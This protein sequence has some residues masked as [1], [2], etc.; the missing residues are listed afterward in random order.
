MHPTRRGSDPGGVRI[1][2]MTRGLGS[3]DRSS[4]AGH[5]HGGRAR[6]TRFLRRPPWNGRGREAGNAP[7]PGWVLVSGVWVRA[8]HW[9]RSGLQA[10]EEG[11]PC[12]LGCR[13][14]RPGKAAGGSWL[15]SALGRR[16]GRC[17]ALLQ[18]GPLRKPAGIPGGRSGAQSARTS[19]GRCPLARLPYRLPDDT[20]PSCSFGRPVSQL[21]R[22]WIGR[23][24]EPSSR[25]SATWT[26]F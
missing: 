26:L 5:A 6:R 11:S 12:V 21:P 16:A 9:R 18:R 19:S 14:K 2:V 3:E 4:P 1:R 10:S 15:R 24:L 25:T 20:R 22:S 23:D 13:P 7:V 17:R 8:S